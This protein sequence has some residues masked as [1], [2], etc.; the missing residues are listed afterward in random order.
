[1]SDATSSTAATLGG[2]EHA[3]R[4]R[5]ARQAVVAGN[6]ANAD[7]PGY[8]RADVDFEAALGAAA[9][10]LR[11][12]DPRH[13]GGGGGSGVGGAGDT[14]WRVVREAA[15]DSPDRNGV[16]FDR[17]L[18]QLSRNAGAF[19]EAATVHARIAALVRLAIEG[20]GS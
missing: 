3:L 9:G 12:S 4:Y 11:T 1:M 13:I 2:L 18:L 7:T 6:V 8:R 17:E 10:R 14:N 20:Q 15:S 19:T 5:L 16:D